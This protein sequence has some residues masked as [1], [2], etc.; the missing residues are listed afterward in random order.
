MKQSLR[1]VILS[2]MILSAGSF[3]YAGPDDTSIPE[4]LD[5][6][7]VTIKAGTDLFGSEGSGTIIKREVE[8]E[9]VTFVWTAAHVVNGL[10]T[11][12]TV[13]VDGVKKEVVHFNP[14]YIL[15]DLYEDNELI[16]HVKLRAVVVKFSE[17]QDLALLRVLKKDYSPSG[18]KFYLEDKP[19]MRGTELYHVGSLLG[20]TGSNSTTDG[21]VSSLGRKPDASDIIYDQTTVTALPGSSGGGVFLKSDGR[22]IGMLVAGYRGSD[23]FNLIVPVRRMLEWAQEAGIL[24]ALKEDVSM[25]TWDELKKI[26]PTGSYTPKTKKTVK[27]DTDTTDERSP[28]KGLYKHVFEYGNKELKKEVRLH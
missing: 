10:K 12:K 8:G 23:G 15:K 24:W 19:P 9:S 6:I 14:L 16:G 28:H 11:T 7:S 27:S 18:A 13:M 4:L 5:E 26:P 25:P 17:E 20:K 2:A 3:S 1:A 21:I 22:Y